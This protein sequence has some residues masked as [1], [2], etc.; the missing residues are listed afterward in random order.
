M[1]LVISALEKLNDY[2]NAMLDLEKLRVNDRF[3][4]LESDTLS[5]ACEAKNALEQMM[6]RPS[7]KPSLFDTCGRSKSDIYVKAIKDI[8]SAVTYQLNYAFNYCVSVITQ[9]PGFSGDREAFLREYAP[10]WAEND[11]VSELGALVKNESVIDI[12]TY[13][14][15]MATI[16]EFDFT[17]LYD[18]FINTFSADK[19]FEARCKNAAK[20]LVSAFGLRYQL[21]EN[22][23]RSHKNGFIITC[24]IYSEPTPSYYS[25]RKSRLWRR[26]AENCHQIYQA[27]EIASR[28]AD[29]DPLF[30]AGVAFNA[31]RASSHWDV[32]YD[33][34]DKFGRGGVLLTMF[35]SKFELLLPND[36]FNSLIA[37]IRTFAAGELKDQKSA[38]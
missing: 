13:Q 12:E 35:N 3:T 1:D 33:S 37:F 18:A 24:D 17:R 4:F 14:A 15:H 23:T 32:S 5:K 19:A 36:A 21:L 20:D 16:A 8:Q 10:I 34:R 27:L 6:Q 38:A 26:G 25:E 11:S 29:S 9:E 22:I 2:K 30:E 28:W 31:L 7:D